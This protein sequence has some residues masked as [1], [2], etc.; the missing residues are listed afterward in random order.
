MA[1]RPTIKDIAR[2]LG[3]STGTVH[4]ALSGKKGVSEETRARVQ[5]T[6]LEL[7]YQPNQAAAGLRR[8]DARIAVLLPVKTN[9]N[10]FYFTYQWDA[11]RDYFDSVRDFNV[12]LISVPYYDTHFLPA[13]MLDDILN[14]HQPSGLLCLGFA[15]PQAV[16]SLRRYAQAHIP[17]VLIGGDIPECG[18]LCS[19]TSPYEILGSMMAEQLIMQS[20]GKPGKFLIAVG[21]AS[22]PSHTRVVDGFC[23]YVK[24][25]DPQREVLRISAVGSVESSSDA[26]CRL[27]RQESITGCCAVSARDSV[28]LGEALRQSGLAGAVPAIG[29]DVFPENIRFLRDGVFTNLIQK[30]PYQMAYVGAQT[31]TEYLLSGKR[32]LKDVLQVGSEMVFR[33]SISLY[34]NGFYRL[35]L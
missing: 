33:S 34:D 31:L 27:F 28:A 18:R 29:S 12:D 35:L 21:S 5:R 6:A 26:L 32:P 3:V 16:A 25:Q 17:V 13:P 4:L 15:G 8:K 10:R 14:H 20:R 23:Q 2:Q 22:F 30:N 1:R 11:V 7:G 19:V 9:L 24:A